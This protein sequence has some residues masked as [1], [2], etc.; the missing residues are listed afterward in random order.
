[1]LF[2]CSV[3]T[4]IYYSVY[5]SYF[6]SLYPSL[7]LL[8]SETDDTLDTESKES[9]AFSTLWQP[10]D[11]D[12]TN[13]HTIII[14]VLLPLLCNQLNCYLKICFMEIVYFGHIHEIN[15]L[16]FLMRNCLMQIIPRQ[17]DNWI[18]FLGNSL[19]FV[20]GWIRSSFQH[21]FSRTIN[22]ELYFLSFDI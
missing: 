10:F 8:L 6:H 19:N 18:R 4:V 2:G 1:M 11:C 13:V 14:I 22:L 21:T 20:R 7:S 3:H 15:H 16:F 17:N 12:C 9:A 5:S